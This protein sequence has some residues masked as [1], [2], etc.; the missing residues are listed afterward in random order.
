MDKEELYRELKKE[1]VSFVSR[2]SEEEKLDELL[3]N[4][5]LEVDRYQDMTQ[6]VLNYIVKHKE[7]DEVK[8]IYNI[9]KKWAC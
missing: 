4:I 9:I 8:E 1:N 7:V 5:A 3:F 2:T 6:E